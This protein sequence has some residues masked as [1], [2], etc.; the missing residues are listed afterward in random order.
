MST[1]FGAYQRDITSKTSNAGPYGSESTIDVVCTVYRT[2]G[3]TIDIT[4]EAEQ[5]ITDKVF[6]ARE[7][8][9]GTVAGFSWEQFCNCR[10]YTLSQVS[11]KL[12]KVSM[13]FSTLYFVDPT[14]SGTIKYQLPAMS[15]Y[16][17]RQ[18]TTKVYRTAWSVVPPPLSNASADIGGT[19]VV[20]GSTAIDMLV[21]QISIRVRATQD[22]S[23]TS[24]LQA[25]TLANYMGKLNSVA[26]MGAPIG[27]V[28]CEGVSVSKT[29]AGTE[30]YEVIF[31]FL[32]DFWAHHEQ[33][34][35]CE[36]T[37]RPLQG[38]TGPSEVKWKRVAR[39]SANF[40]DIYGSPADPVL[41]N[42]IEKGYWT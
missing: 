1:V 24:M 5:M 20:G 39:D 9:W 7:A 12:I 37:G 32:Y 10:S 14:S 22:S 2:D 18:R 42:L 34:P 19:N 28:L 15:E 41:K 30:Y 11:G 8:S 13:H 4:S 26:F 16:T 31:E 25:T 33:V 35:T 40:N 6:T 38:S 27:T 21:P 3:A 17:A 23:V 29:G 36:P